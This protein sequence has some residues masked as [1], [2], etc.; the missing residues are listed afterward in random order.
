MDGIEKDNFW[1]QATR[2]KPDDI[3]LSPVAERLWEA[4]GHEAREGFSKDPEAM[5][6]LTRFML[7][8]PALVPF[9]T[10]NPEWTVELFL[11]GE[12]ASGTLDA[13]DREAFLGQCV[14]SKDDFALARGIVRFRNCHLVRLYSQ[15]ILGL[16]PAPEIWR[17][18]AQVTSISIQGALEGC[19]L[20]LKDRAEGVRLAVI[21]MGKLGGWELNFSSDIDIIYVY[22]PEP[23]RGLTKTHEVAVQWARLL[24][25]VLERVTEEGPSY[26]VDLGLRPGG[27]DGDLAMT[28]E[29]AELYYQTQAAG[30]ERWALLKA[31]PV[32]G[33]RALGAEFVE[34][35]RPF[36]YR[37]FLDYGSL[38]DIRDLKERIQREIRSG[39]R[40]PADVKMGQGGI[41]ELEFLVQTFQ[42]IYGGKLPSLRGRDTM[43]VLDALVKH[44]LFP[45]E[46]GR[47]LCEAYLFL[48]GVEH[49]VQMV[50]HRQVHRVPAMEGERRRISWLMGYE[51]AG[52]LKRFMTDLGLYM[53]RVHRAFDGLLEGQRRDLS[54]QPEP[55]VEEVLLSLDDE[56][57]SLSLFQKAGFQEAQISRE[58]LRRILTER[59][60]AHRSP[61]A[62]RLLHDL[63]PR[64]LAQVM[65][66]S[67]PDQTLFRLEKFLEAV[68]PR[69]GYYAL[70][71]E[72]P[73]T[74]ENLI[75]L[76]GQSALLSRWL[77]THLEAVDVLIGRGHHRPRREKA[78]LLQELEELMS[79]V[80]DTE[81][82]LGKL[83]G[84]RAQEILRIGAADLWGVLSPLEVGVELTSLAEVFL[85]VT[86]QEVL[87][88]A[89]CKQREPMIPLCIL[90]LGTFGGR[91]LSYRSD[92]DIVFIYEEG[93][94]SRFPEGLS[95]VEH[96]TRIGQ[97]LLSW[98]TIP[99]KEGP[100]W[101][102]DVRLRPSGN[103]GPLMV[104]L[105]VFD[106]YY[107]EQGHTWEL[108]ALLKARPCSGD[109][110]T[111]EKVVETIHRLMEQAVLPQAEE[112][113]AMRMRMERERGSGFGDGGI[114][115][116]L[117]PGGTTDIEFLVQYHQMA[118]WA[119]DPALRTSMTPAVLQRLTE[120]G[121]IPEADGRFLL[122]AHLLFKGLENR[123]GLVLDYKGTDQPCTV[124]DLKALG[125]LEG[126]SKGIPC[127]GGDD[128]TKHLEGVMAKVREIYLR[129][130]LGAS[131]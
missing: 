92:L 123:L 104:S 108:Q 112:V 126:I 54:G 12:I 16:R 98:I 64:I 73:K 11:G 4:L 5:G 65:K 102:V 130:L 21:G 42:I 40:L 13:S 8:S 99:M 59:F 2:Q 23:K 44:D 81:E 121:V 101:A 39:R 55:I 34:M 109:M 122:E 24:T 60:P 57:T 75:V 105:P 71:E 56:E 61:K 118:R 20:L 33:D 74:L 84:F 18:W 25:S 46:E 49:R 3:D 103:R 48:R 129:S 90:A 63:M 127:P 82:R 72:N 19:R 115:L 83:R 26:R 86:L 94:R 78:D 45:A 6:R 36:V 125:P 100:G 66:T 62:R 22:M 93:G 53:E 51:G 69:G 50:H 70:L 67:S 96:I 35:V 9:L 31:G 38:E 110:Q 29:A 80:K 68:G 43:G 52:G 119:S 128:L 37:K 76:F 88:I 47:A 27:K 32:A 114:H 107:R 89:G 30:W 120:T 116:K 15:E 1:A 28:P 10:R 41:R 58:T 124:E 79:G 113:H 111:G 95:E 77:E 91:E 17:E 97:R 14:G 117:G 106:R 131:D 85:E 7:A 87:S